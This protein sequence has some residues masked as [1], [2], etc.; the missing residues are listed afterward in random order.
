LRYEHKLSSA[1]ASI[2]AIHAS[3]AVYGADE[4]SATPSLEEITVTAQRRSESIQNVPI[5]VT[6]FS[7]DT[8]QKLNI[9]TFDDVL[10]FV[11]NVTAA[12][13]GPGMSNVYIRGSSSGDS[14][15]TQNGTKSR[16][17]VAWHIT[18][19][20]MLH[21]TWS[22]GFRPGGF[23]RVSTCHVQGSDGVNQHRIPLFYTSDDMTNN[24]LGWKTGWFERRLQVNGAVYQENWNNAKISFI[25]PGALGN[26]FFIS[27]RTA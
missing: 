6:A 22:H 1:I 4:E 11:P 24:E 15:T 18:P 21:Y 20:V 14:G 8:P 9:S 25:D 12:S 16:A 23:N 17:N 27:G 10:K 26:L 5:A 19:D 2:L 7:T 13:K 3:G